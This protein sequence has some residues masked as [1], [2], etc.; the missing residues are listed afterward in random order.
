MAEIGNRNAGSAP[1]NWPRWLLILGR[2]FLGC[3]FG[4]AAY[5]KLRQPWML[6]AMAVDSYQILPGWGVTLVARTLPWLELALALFVLTGWK[7]RWSAAAV[8]GLLAVFFGVMVHS[9]MKGLTIDCGCFG[10]GEKLGPITLLRDGALLAVSLG[11]TIGAFFAAC[12]SGGAGR[13]IGAAAPNF[14]G[15]K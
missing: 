11:V 4:Y 13:K 3:V 10:P 14:S 5:T 15:V 9:Y 6:F 12:S 8:S 7:L 2:I 1:V